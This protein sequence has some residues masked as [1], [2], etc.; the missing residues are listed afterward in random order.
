MPQDVET[1]FA[2]VAQASPKRRAL[3]AY[4]R[5][6]GREGLESFLPFTPSPVFIGSLYLLWHSRH[7]WLYLK[8]Q[9][10]TFSLVETCRL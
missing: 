6:V 8:P 10:T 5:R 1:T 9:Y 3:A 2:L 7:F 4:L